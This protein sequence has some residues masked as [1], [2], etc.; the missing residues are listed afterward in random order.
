MTIDYELF[1]CVAQNRYCDNF[2]VLLSGCNV[3]RNNIILR[4]R[5]HKAAKTCKCPQKNLLHDDSI[6]SIIGAF[7]YTPYRHRSVS[8]EETADCN[9]DLFISWTTPRHA[10]PV[11]CNS[12]QSVVLYIYTWKFR[13]I[14][15][16]TVILLI[17]PFTSTPQ[18][19]N[20]SV[21]SIIIIIIA[22]ALNSSIIHERTQKIWRD[23]N[24]AF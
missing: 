11:C 7:F 24:K 8:V 5:T 2:A 9:H 22:V 15:F 4:C 12:L 13:C 20:I 1:E 21:T 17:I 3:D 18:H 19:L 6:V 23:F 10:Q 14:F 16:P